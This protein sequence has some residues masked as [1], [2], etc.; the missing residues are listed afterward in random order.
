MRNK[1]ERI[2]SFG[3]ADT[4]FRGPTLPTIAAREKDAGSSPVSEYGN[5]TVLGQ[6]PAIQRDGSLDYSDYDRSRALGPLAVVN[7]STPN[8]EK[9]D[10]MEA[11]ADHSEAPTAAAS[12]FAKGRNERA[13]LRVSH[14]SER[15]VP[16]PPVVY[17][18]ARQIDVRIKRKAVPGQTFPQR[19]TGPPRQPPR[20]MQNV[21]RTPAFWIEDR[22]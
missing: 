18:Q 2:P 22:Y 1:H 20:A 7:L 11:R 10:P 12:A 5:G 6:P 13:S 21:P 9:E 15:E 17:H 4:S 3:A 8:A 19:Q 14:I 16:P